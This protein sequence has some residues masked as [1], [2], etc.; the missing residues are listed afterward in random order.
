MNKSFERTGTGSP[1]N[2]SITSQPHTGLSAVGQQI[3]VGLL[4]RKQVAARWHVCPHT[5]A[6]RKDI[7]PVRFGR[8]LLRY[9]L[10]DI[11]AIEAA[12]AK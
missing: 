6:R 1:K 9:R 7:Q 10:A 5:V 8:R 12:A 11:E 3:L 4:T 2:P